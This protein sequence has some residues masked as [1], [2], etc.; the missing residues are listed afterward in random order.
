V[1][2]AVELIARRHPC[3]RVVS[4]REPWSELVDVLRGVEHLAFGASTSNRAQGDVAG[5]GR[6]TG[7][8]TALSQELA[9]VYRK[10]DLLERRL[11]E[12]VMVHF[13]LAEHTVQS[14]VYHVHQPMAELCTQ[15]GIS[16]GNRFDQ[17][18]VVERCRDRWLHH[19]QQRLQRE[20]VGHWRL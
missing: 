13:A 11:D 16:P 9:A 20:G 8:K 17:R 12:I 4:A 2:E 1:S 3:L 10:Y 6:S 18:L 5:D 19:T 14:A 7:R 15:C